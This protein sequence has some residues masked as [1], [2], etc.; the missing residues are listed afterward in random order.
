MKCE[1][2]KNVK[3]KMMK[4]VLTSTSN[5]INDKSEFYLG[6]QK[7]VDD[8]FNV[9]VSFVDLFKRYKNNVKLLMNEQKEVWLKFVQYYETQ[10]DT[11]VSN[12]LKRY[13]NWLFDYIFYDINNMSPNEFLSL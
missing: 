8:S 6:F 9:F 5:N 11:N 2:L 12:Y 1:P 13:N 7:G 10:S 4:D 3:Q